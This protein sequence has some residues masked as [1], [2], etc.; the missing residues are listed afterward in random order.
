[1]HAPNNKWPSEFSLESCRKWR[2]GQTRAEFTQ[3]SGAALLMEM[4]KRAENKQLAKM[5]R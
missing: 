2:V 3:G 5:G 4:D 1:M